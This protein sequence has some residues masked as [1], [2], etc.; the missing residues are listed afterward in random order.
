MHKTQL[1]N[2]PVQLRWL[3]GVACEQNCLSKN[4]QFYPLDGALGL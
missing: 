1:L 2:I 4:A 3:M